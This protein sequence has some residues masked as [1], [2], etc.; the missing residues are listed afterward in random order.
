MGKEEKQRYNAAVNL[1]GSIV[2][3][4]LPPEAQN[5]VDSAIQTSKAVGN[6]LYGIDDRRDNLK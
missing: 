6:I 2:K 3:V 1:V 4:S 5:D